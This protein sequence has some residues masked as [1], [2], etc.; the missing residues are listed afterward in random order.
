MA[1]RPRHWPRAEASSA[2]GVAKLA[3]QPGRQ[4]LHSLLSQM[5]AVAANL[6]TVHSPAEGAV[7]AQFAVEVKHAGAG[8]RGDDYA[9][10]PIPPGHPDWI[11]L[12]IQAAVRLLTA[13]V[14]RLGGHDDARASR[15]Q[16]GNRPAEQ[17]GQVKVVARVAEMLPSALVI[18]VHRLP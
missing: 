11:V 15:T 9:Q 5:D 2:G 4:P 18:V 17:G 16:Q 6:H 14:I 10:Q 13:S 8:M 1:F 3:H 7:G 12:R